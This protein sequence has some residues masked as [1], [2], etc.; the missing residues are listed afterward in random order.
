MAAETHVDR[1]IDN[2]DQFIKSNIFGVYNLF[3]NEIEDI[4]PGCV[5]QD[6][7]EYKSEFVTKKTHYSEVKLKKDARFS[8]FCLI[9]DSAHFNVIENPESC[10]HAINDLSL[11]H[12]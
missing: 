4:Y 8:R 11:I 5:F 1:S 3:R 12:I 7:S 10:A 2:P 9:P 6:E